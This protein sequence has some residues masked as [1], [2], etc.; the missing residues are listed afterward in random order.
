MRTFI[1]LD[2]SPEI[3][4]RLAGFIGRLAPL[5][6]GVKWVSQESMHL[7]LKFLGEIDETRA[8]QVKDI[9]RSVAG[10]SE[11]LPLRFQGTG[12]FPP[13]SS[14]PRVLWVGIEAPPGL[15]LLQEKVEDGCQA[16]G[17]ARETRPFHAHLTL[18]RVNFSGSLAALL[19][20]FNRNPS[21]SFGEMTAQRL[22]FFLS[23]LKPAGA[24]Y[25]V[26]EEFDLR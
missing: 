9:L 8:A 11:A 16:I 15:A 1:A 12:A 24:E 22:T 19:N 6:R 25:S 23:R 10:Q 7:T 3:K 20:E 17:F 14:C 4:A 5:G 18:G 21:E 2:L 26:L 13:G